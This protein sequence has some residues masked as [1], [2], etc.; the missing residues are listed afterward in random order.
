MVSGGANMYLMYLFPIVRLSE[1]RGFVHLKKWVQTYP[2]KEQSIHNYSQSVIKHSENAC[3]LKLFIE[4]LC[5]VFLWGTGLRKA[6]TLFNT[7]TPET[8]NFCS[9]FTHE[10]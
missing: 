5:S 6:G 3:R 2:T 4:F 8:T 9:N 7:V 10:A 1:V